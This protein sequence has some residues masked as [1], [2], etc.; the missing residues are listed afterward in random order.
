MTLFA[1]LAIP[2]QARVVYTP[3]NVTLPRG[4]YPIDLNHDGIPDFYFQRYSGPCPIGPGRLYF[5]RVA[6]NLTGG[7]IVGTYDADALPSGV[8]IDSSQSFYGGNSLM[9]QSVIGC[10]GGTHGQWLHAYRLYLGLKFLIAGQVHY[11]WAQLSTHAGGTDTLYGFAYETIP[12]MAIKT[13]QIFDSP[14]EPGIGP[15]SAESE[16]SGPTA[17][18]APPL[19]AAPQLQLSGNASP[20]ALASQEQQQQNK[21]Q[22]RYTVTDLG[23]LGGTFA[24]ASGINNRGLVEGTSTL[25]GNQRE[26]AFV[27]RNG[28]MTDLGTLGGPSSIVF[29]SPNERG[30]LAGNAETLMLDPLGEDICGQGDHLICL[31][32]VWQKGVMTALPTTLGGSNGYAHGV[33]NRGQ[34]VGSAENATH[35]P[36]CMPPQ[37]LDFEPVIWKPKHMKVEIIQLLLLPGDTVGDAL[38]VNDNGVAVGITGVCISSNDHAV[39]WQDGTVSDLGN[40]GGTTNNIPFAINNEGQAVGSSNLPGDTNFHAF[41][42]QRGVMTDLG[43]LSGDVSSVAYSITSEG[44]MVGTSYDANG[45][46]RAFL[47]ERGVMKDL[48]TLIPVG[49]PLFLLDAYALNENGEIVGDALQVSTGE[50]RAFLATPCGG[51]RKDGE[52]CEDGGEGAAGTG[53]A[54]LRPAISI[55]E[56]VRNLLKQQQAR[57]Y[58]IPVQPAAPSN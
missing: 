6:P 22:P 23:T 32:F 8:Q 18:V 36:T 12:G 41:I 16:D 4:Y 40:L 28:V 13:G 49:S 56:N 25:A 30:E 5:L 46:P 10:G 53:G 35:D 27:W 54:S 51:D 44:Q 43:T 2:A 47:R 34:I 37:V 7:G 29:Y 21:K 57:R 50:V 48:N 39:L 55:P 14:D 20:A 17:S 1:A 19:S 42:W 31:P 58:H 26:H 15:G 3:V 38:W 33:N 45:N 52:G 24:Y 9:Y 11:G